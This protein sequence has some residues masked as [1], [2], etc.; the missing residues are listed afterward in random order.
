MNSA[1]LWARS[2]AHFSSIIWPLG[3]IMLS[4]YLFRSNACWIIFIRVSGGSACLTYASSGAKK[5][6]N[7]LFFSLLWNIEI[8]NFGGLPNIPLQVQIED[9]K[10][11]L[12]QLLHFKV[13]H[14]LIPISINNVDK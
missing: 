3:I 6:M 9:N 10:L 1:S 5:F 7:T 12:L 11:L 13:V 14:V 2:A 8:I 4:S